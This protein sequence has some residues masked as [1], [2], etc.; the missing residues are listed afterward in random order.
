MNV[1]R[2]AWRWY[3]RVFMHTT[4][5]ATISGLLIASAIV[6][7]LLHY[8]L[9]N[10]WALELFDYS[11]G[12]RGF[13][14]AIVGTMALYGLL[15]GFAFHPALSF[16]YHEWLRHTPWKRGRPLPVG[17]VA[18]TWQDCVLLGGATL[19]ATLY[20]PQLPSPDTVPLGP[21]IALLLGFVL[22]WTAANFVTRN[23]VWLYATLAV[24]PLVT[25]ALYAF[26]ASAGAVGLAIAAIVAYV[27]VWR[28]LADFPWE[29]ARWNQQHFQWL[30]NPTERRGVNWQPQAVVGWPYAHL[31]HPPRDARLSW[32][33]TGLEAI[34]AASWAACVTRV[35]DPPGSDLSGVL[36]MFVWWLAI[37]KLIGN[38]SV[39]CPD[40]CLGHRIARRR[41]II[42]SHDR[43]LVEPLLVGGVTLAFGHAWLQFEPGPLWR[44]AGLTVAVGVLATR[45]IGAPIDTSF[46]T[47]PR[48]V[49][50]HSPQRQH[51]ERLAASGE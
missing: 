22:S 33:W 7:L 34:T 3:R 21:A 19:V 43:L 27:G 16:R 40:L 47:G 15:R 13:Y 35:L 6:M 29:V 37:A 51:F 14:A 2:E 24:G 38:A 36:W 45:R 39:V 44:G 49:R 46:Y 11:I 28:G 12:L 50:G 20:A 26:D 10:R 4:L 25:L 1:F 31:L 17:S 41:P 18:P 9:F 30:M 23:Y 42:W 8:T 48:V 32:G 5:V